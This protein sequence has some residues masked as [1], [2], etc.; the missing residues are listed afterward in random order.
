M[1]IFVMNKLSKNR[2]TDDRKIL[3][4]FKSLKPVSNLEIHSSQFTEFDCYFGIKLDNKK[5]ND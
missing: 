4:Q 1:S 3:K 5:I 2:L